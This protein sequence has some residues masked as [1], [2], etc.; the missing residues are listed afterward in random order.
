MELTA[1]RVGSDLRALVIDQISADPDA[2]AALARGLSVPEASI[3]VL[4]RRGHWDLDL[5]LVSADVLGLEIRVGRD[6]TAE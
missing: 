6:R 4:M 1:Q 3:D 5:A 2:K